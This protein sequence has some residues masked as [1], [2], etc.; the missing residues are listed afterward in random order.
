VGPVVEPLLGPVVE[1][2]LGPVVEPLLGP[3][4]EPLD[5]LLEP[6]ELLEPLDPP[7][8]PE[9]LDPLEP[10]LLWPPPLSSLPLSSLLL[11]LLL[12]LSRSETLSSSDFL[13]GLTSAA[14]AA[15]T[16]TSRPST[17]VPFA[18]SR[19][20]A[21]ATTPGLSRTSRSPGLSTSATT[22][23][24]ADGSARAGGVTGASATGT[25]S[26]IAPDTTDWANTVTAPSA[27]T[28]STAAV[29]AVVVRFIASALR[30]TESTGGRMT[31]RVRSSSRRRSAV[32]ARSND[33]FT[34]PPRA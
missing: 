10:P 29:A 28:V 34:V 6:L 17:T 19:E 4:V 24:G 32:A 13:S 16:V 20:P 23:C 3:V 30:I 11:S 15:E 26:G 25:G 21:G 18:A 8:P 22:G 12:S 7:D 5:P 31:P 27:P 33:V 2:L 14:S 1:P 9:L